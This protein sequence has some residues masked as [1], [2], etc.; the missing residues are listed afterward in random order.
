MYGK[1]SFQGNSRPAGRLGVH[2]DLVH[3][4]SLNQVVETPGEMR[5]DQCGTW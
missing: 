4:R 1:H 2:L 3:G 5:Q